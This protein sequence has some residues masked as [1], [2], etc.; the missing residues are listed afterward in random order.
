MKRRRTILYAD[1]E[2]SILGLAALCLEA[3]GFEAL[4]APDGETAVRLYEKHARRIDAVMLDLTMPGL[5]GQE[6]ARAIRAM[7]ATIPITLVSG[8]GPEDLEGR[9]DSGLFDAFLT[10]PFT[11]ESLGGAIRAL[12][13]VTS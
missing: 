5:D 8:Y 7:G 11:L 9:I 13:G 1:D 12:L 10:K 3:L 2:S 4:T 6:A